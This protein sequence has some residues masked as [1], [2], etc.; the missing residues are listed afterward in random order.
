MLMLML[1]LQIDSLSLDQ[2]LA[3]GLNVSPA[4]QESK[5]T[6]DKSRIAFFQ[7]L[8]TLLPTVSTTGSYTMTE[9]PNAPTGPTERY[10]TNMNFSMPLFDLDVLGS[11]LVSGLTWKSNR[12]QH[13]SD[14]TNLILQIKS[15]YYG[16]ANAR[17][18]LRYSDIAIHRSDE[19]L[20]LIKTKFELGAASRLDLLQAEVLYLQTRQVK[21]RTKTQEITAQEQLKSLLGQTRDVYPMDTLAVPQNLTFPPLDSLVENLDRVNYNLRLAREIERAA[22]INLVTAYLAFLPR[23]SGFYGFSTS[24]ESLHTDLGWY[25]DNATKNWGISVSFPIFE[26]KG[27]VFKWLNARKDYQLKKLSR[28]Q[29]VLE[30]VKALRTTYYGLQES[31]ENLQ[32][33]QRSYEAAT[34]A[35]NIAQ[36][37]YRLGALS[38][39]N[40]LKVEGDMY[41]SKTAYSLALSEFFVQQLNF[42]YLLGETTFN[43][44]P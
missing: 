29:T 19:N 43:K 6:L 9:Y 4:Y 39:I 37:Q 23:V 27:L 8:C 10:S 18:L 30:T 3:R 33:S 1:C 13:R 7:S 22:K 44:E 25:P 24:S 38:L 16:L 35:A 26:I 28:Q 36:E 11:I 17:E 2:A 21:A 40:W 34:E 32:L 12:I 41:T 15:A 20:T 42:S 31:Y 5:V 14:L